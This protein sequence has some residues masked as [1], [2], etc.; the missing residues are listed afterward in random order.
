MS[1]S[2][3]SAEGKR[4]A[5][6]L[7]REWMGFCSAFGEEEVEE[8]FEPPTMS[9]E[10]YL[11]Q[12]QPQKKEKTSK[13]GKP[14]VSAGDKDQ[15][16]SEQDRSKASANSSG[17]SQKSASHKRTS[18]NKAEEKLPESPKPKRVRVGGL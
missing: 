1:G 3:K 10:S 15:G 5:C 13:V 2:L 9:F 14:S 18:K 16:H 4:K 11:T 6:D 7:D 12:N 8:E 17:S